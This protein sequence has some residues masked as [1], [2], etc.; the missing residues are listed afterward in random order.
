MHDYED[1]ITYNAFRHLWDL[2]V[3]MQRLLILN[4]C[5][6]ASQNKPRNANYV[7]FLTVSK[8]LGIPILLKLKYLDCQNHL[9]FYK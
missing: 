3:N 5:P 9:D 4:M 2:R 7:R 1:I 6:K 8:S